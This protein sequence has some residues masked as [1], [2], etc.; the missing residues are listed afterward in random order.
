MN[1]KIE[2]EIKEIV[3][4]KVVSWAFIEYLKSCESKIRA[5][6]VKKIILSTVGSFFLFNILNFVF[7][8]EIKEIVDGTKK[9][10]KDTILKFV[11]KISEYKNKKK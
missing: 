2:K 4:N 7:R 5:Q 6:I 1:Q 11:D 3:D 8:K 9:I 10:T